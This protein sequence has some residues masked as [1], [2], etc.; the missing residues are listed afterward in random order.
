MGLGAALR[1]AK[2][3]AALAIAFADI[4]GLW[5]VDEVTRRLSRIAELALRAALA[6]LLRARARRGE[7]T[8]PYPAEPERACGYVILGLGKLGAHELNYSSDIDLIALFDPVRL[9]PLRDGEPQSFCVR[10]TR[11]VMRLLDERTAEGYVF[12]TDLR[13]RPD[14]GATP[15]ALSTVAAENYYES[16][17]QNLERAAMIKA[18]PVAGDWAVGEAFLKALRPYLWRKHLDF[19]A[20]ADIHSIKRQIVAH[21]GGGQIAVEGHNVKLG[22]GGIREIEFFVQT[23]QLIWGGR[24]PRLRLRGTLEG[25]ATLV[26]AGRLDPAEAERL[27]RAY[28][29]LRRVEHRLQMVDDRQTH[30]LP[31]TPA[32]IAGFARFLGYETADGFRRDLLGQ[33]ETVARSFAHL[34]EEESPLAGSGSLVFTG[35]EHDPETLATLAHLGY[36]DPVAVSTTVQNW[37]RGR[38]RAMR[39][40]RARELLTELTPQLL[41]AL[42]RTIE[43]TQALLRFD[44]FLGELPSGVQLFALFAANPALLDLVAEIMGLAPR[45]AEM[46]ARNPGLLDAVLDR[47]FFAPLSTKSDLV[48]ALEA[49]LAPADDMQ[50]VLDIARRFANDERFRI[51]VLW[52]RGLANTEAAGR[53]T[54]DLVD[55]LLVA[56]VPRVAQELAKAHG[57]VPGGHFAVLALG[58]YGSRELTAGSDLDLVLLYDAPAETRSDGKQPLSAMHFYQR[59]AQRLIAAFTSPTGEGK[60]F[61]VDL[62]LRPQGNAGPL[63]STLDGF[64]DYAR[65]QAWTWERMALTGAR[66]AYAEGDMETRIDAALLAVLTME[67]AAPALLLAVAEM[68]LRIDAEHHSDNPWQIKHVRGGLVDCEFIAQALQLLHAHARPAVLSTSTHGAFR[69]LAEAGVLA[70]PMA[71]ELIA[72]TRL[73]LTLQAWLRLTATNTDDEH[74]WPPALRQALARAGEAKDFATLGAKMLAVAARIRQIYAEL[75]EGPAVTGS[76]PT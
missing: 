71:E 56:L 51:G 24:E 61:E 14:P 44:P 18:R 17:G 54:S 10:L 68:R 4:T 63:A 30:T 49:R 9:P 42:A 15:L 21:K 46:L 5:T 55:A 59:F 47:E 45:L 60:L 37:H 43:P 67:R 19:A 73:W 26:A 6:G 66:V 23:Q 62:R 74:S 75:I 64:R 27:T 34:F 76:K 28:R 38:Y 22:R 53:A 41:A 20:I 25:L 32:G 16:A 35:T 2:R 40:A 39:S 7:I 50:D 1:N 3:R 57:R 70:P 8:L 65:S 12:R 48:P 58:K 69:R 11:D 36:A 72:A 29:F 13:L 52:L 31:N 33:L